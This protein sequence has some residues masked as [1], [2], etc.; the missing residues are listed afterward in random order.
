MEAFAMAQATDTPLVN[1]IR[2]EYREMPGLSLTKRQM[3]RLWNL[4][5]ATC[6]AAIEALVSAHVLK[7]T[8][9]DSYVLDGRRG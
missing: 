9:R 8:P 5:F 7:R 3:Q 2:A 6:T 1:L 4:D